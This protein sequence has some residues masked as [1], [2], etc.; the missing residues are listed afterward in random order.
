VETRDMRECNGQCA[1]K[2][3]TIKGSGGCHYFHPILPMQKSIT[4]ELHIL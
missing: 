2:I 3:G 1:I 4:P